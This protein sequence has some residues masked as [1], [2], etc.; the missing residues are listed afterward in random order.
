M[1]GVELV[2]FVF[3]VNK[4]IADGAEWFHGRRHVVALHDPS[5]SPLPN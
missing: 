3:G 1:C 2:T 4:L 5:D